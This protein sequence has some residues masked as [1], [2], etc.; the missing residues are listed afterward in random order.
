[1]HR[2]SAVPIEM[3]DYDLMQSE[4]D[5]LYRQ[6]QRDLDAADASMQAAE[7]H[8]V[9]CGLLSV[10]KDLPQGWLTELFD[11]A[12]EGDL[13]VAECRQQ[14]QRIH[15]LTAGQM[16]GPGLGMS[17]LL[18]AD[19]QPIQVKARAVADWCQGYL[20]GVGIAAGDV[21]KC[22]NED[23]REAL[24]DIAEVTRMDIDALQ[25]IEEEQDAL[26]EITEF[27]WVAA[28]LVREHLSAAEEEV[29]SDYH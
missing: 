2:Q 19:D 15:E 18:P 29:G 5:E 12:G 9:I 7:V 8:G 1:M 16:D 3:N 11:Q 23:G 13:L 28:M 27:L 25:D 24:Q 26:T 17:L 22:L 14:I 6:L 20:Y 10:Q 21:E 4:T